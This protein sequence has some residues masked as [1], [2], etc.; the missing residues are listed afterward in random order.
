[1]EGL[2]VAICISNG[3]FPS[4]VWSVTATPARSVILYWMLSVVWVIFKIH[5]VSGTGSVTVIRCK[6][7]M[8]T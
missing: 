8:S 4:T 3:K 1:M 2:S 6:G 5:D 7:G